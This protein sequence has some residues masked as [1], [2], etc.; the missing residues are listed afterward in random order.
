MKLTRWRNALLLT[1]G[2]ALGLPLSLLGPLGPIPALALSWD[3]SLNTSNVPTI[4]YTETSPAF[5]VTVTNIGTATWPAG[6]TTPV[7]VAVYFTNEN[8][9]A[10]SHC[11]YTLP[12]DVAP[13][14]SA[15]VHVQRSG[16]FEVG[17]Y[18]LDVNLVKETQFWFDT[19]TPNL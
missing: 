7:R 13:N 3:A 2:L 19:Q 16:P 5:D 11:R 10:C 17:S 9:D 4:W 15:T 12:Y 6:G 18:T 14:G 1:I 8:R